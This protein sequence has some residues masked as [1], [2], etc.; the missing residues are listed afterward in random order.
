MHSA[1]VEMHQCR[2]AART[3]TRWGAYSV[4]QAPDPD[5]RMRGGCE[6]KRNGNGRKTESE[7]GQEETKEETG[8]RIEKWVEEKK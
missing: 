2:L 8:E 5:L 7:E 3:A 1:A 6:S 4:P